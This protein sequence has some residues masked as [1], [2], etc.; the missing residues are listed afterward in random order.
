MLI[1]KRAIDSE[2]IKKLSVVKKL[3]LWPDELLKVHERKFLRKQMR[4]YVFLEYLLWFLSIVVIVMYIITSYVHPKFV[5]NENWPFCVKMAYK[6]L[7]FAFCT[8]QYYMANSHLN[9]YTYAMLYNYLQMKILI[10]YIRS[11]IGSQRDL[12]LRS[13]QRYGQIK[14][15]LFCGE[16]TICLLNCRCFRHGYEIAKACGT[17]SLLHFFTV[18]SVISVSIYSVLFV[19]NSL[20]TLIFIAYVFFFKKNPANYWMI[21]MVVLHLILSAI[22]CINCGQ[23]FTEAVN[24]LVC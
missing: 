22:L 24:N 8:C 5:Y 9:Y 6:L 10:S 4:F 16:N 15:Y 21:T 2:K 18:I 7:M 1:S 12:L 11:G 14:K 13:I 3:R 19:S 17:I 20:E 23:L